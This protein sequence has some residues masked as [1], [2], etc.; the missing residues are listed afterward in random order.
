MT[1]I[2]R[3]DSDPRADQDDLSLMTRG[4]FLKLAAA[5]TSGAKTAAL[6]WLKKVG[7]DPVSLPIQYSSAQ[8][9]E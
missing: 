2:P 9:A 8:K 3:T 6:N 4:N 1:E 5:S 7:F